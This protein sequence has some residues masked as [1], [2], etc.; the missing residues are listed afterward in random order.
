MANKN[1][2]T[3]NDQKIV[4]VKK[5]KPTWRNGWFWLF[6]LL[7]VAIIFGAA[8][9]WGLVTKP[10]KNTDQVLQQ[11]LQ[12]QQEAQNNS[13]D[14]T[15]TFDLDLNKEQVNSIIANYIDD[16]NLEDITAQ[17]NDDNKFVIA[18]TAQIAGKKINYLINFDINQVG[19]NIELTA[20]DAK[21][22]SVDIPVQT[23]LTLIQ[24]NIGNSKM[25]TI[26]PIDS[27]ITIKADNI[28]FDSNQNVTFKLDKIDLENDKINFTGTLN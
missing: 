7:L 26:S 3:E 28:H 6:A 11:Q 27:K 22:G 17:V 18:G 13:D 2:S 14:K 12:T 16:Q 15:A 25:V 19:N 1:N 5:N 4:Y 24:D 10:N 9:F 23:A 20:T 8:Y 21:F